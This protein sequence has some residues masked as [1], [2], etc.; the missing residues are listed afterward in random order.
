MGSQGLWP[1]QSGQQPLG[2]G[3]SVHLLFPFPQ[4]KKV[5][6]W[7]KKHSLEEEEKQLLQS[8]TE[9]LRG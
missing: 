9:I 5:L 1:Q 8:C 2:K 6:K 3:P 4:A 7:L